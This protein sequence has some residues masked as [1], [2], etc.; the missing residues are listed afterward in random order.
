MRDTGIWKKL[1][2]GE[3]FP[4]IIG[5]KSSYFSLESIFGKRFETNKSLFDM[6]FDL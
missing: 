2:D 4:T 5:E 3:K 6:R 1:A